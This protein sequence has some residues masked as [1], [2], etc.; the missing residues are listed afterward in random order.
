[1]ALQE[2]GASRGKLMK[3]DAQLILGEL[4]EDGIQETLD[5]VTLLGTLPNPVISH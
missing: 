4:R 5:M 1:M 2:N 3:Q